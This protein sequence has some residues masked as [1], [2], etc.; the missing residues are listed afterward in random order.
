VNHWRGV[1]GT[2]DV[3]TGIGWTTALMS[4][5]IGITGLIW[6]RAFRNI[7]APPLVIIVDDPEGYFTFPTMFRTIVLILTNI[8]FYFC[9]IK[10]KL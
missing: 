1:W 9:C 5:V 6:L 10:V 2:L 3:Y 4:I 8:H 7:M